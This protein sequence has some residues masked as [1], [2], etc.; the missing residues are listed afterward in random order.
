MSIML[1]KKKLLV[2]TLCPHKF[3]N[4]WYTHI[5]AQAAVL[6]Q[7]GD[8]FID[9]ELPVDSPLLF[10]WKSSPVSLADLSVQGI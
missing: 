1:K 2:R 8:A 10:T 7:V 3:M 6:S 9:K 4:A 5:L